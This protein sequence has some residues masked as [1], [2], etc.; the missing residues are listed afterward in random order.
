M[1][2][3]VDGLYA[4]L[5]PASQL[6]ASSRSLPCE[7]AQKPEVLVVAF[8]ASQGEPEWLG[9]LGKVLG[10]IDAERRHSTVRR[11]DDVLAD[12]KKKL[13]CGDVVHNDWH[14]GTM[15]HEFCC[16]PE[17]DDKPLACH[18]LHDTTFM[19]LADFDVLCLCQSEA[20][21]Y[22]A[23]NGGT[24]GL[25][26]KLRDIL[27]NYKRS[28]FLGVSMGGFGALLHSH[29]ADTVAVFGPQTNLARSHLRP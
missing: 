11:F 1:P 20:N 25:E 27:S 22:C 5:L 19:Q 16:T 14:T 3:C 6:A 18:K 28:L 17:P 8:S 26:E 9:S 21:W 15:W 10:I 12:L 13:S 29:L 4:K 2:W 7:R 23:P 24:L